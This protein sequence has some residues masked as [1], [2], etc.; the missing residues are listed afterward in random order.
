MA[1]STTVEAHLEAVRGWAETVPGVEQV[2]PFGGLVDDCRRVTVVVE[3]VEADTLDELGLGR[4]LWEANVGI[5][6]TVLAPRPSRPRNAAVSAFALA[7]D[8]GLQARWKHLGGAGP[9]RLVRVDREVSPELMGHWDSARVVLEQTVRFA[10]SDVT[11]RQPEHVGTIY[12][13]Q[14]PNI[15]EGHKNDYE[16]ISD[17]D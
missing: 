8:L 11:A 7:L 17:V 2:E 1:E 3:V 16:E 6:L 14:P 9:V 13:S 15:G 4:D 12:A 10:P 5:E